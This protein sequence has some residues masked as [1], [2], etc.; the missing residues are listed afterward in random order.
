[1]NLKE[2]T[3]GLNRLPQGQEADVLFL[4]GKDVFKV[5]GVYLRDEK[6][7]FTLE[8][9]GKSLSQR[10]VGQTI[11]DP[12]EIRKI[13]GCPHNRYQGKENLLQNSVCFR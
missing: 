13:T 8:L 11:R 9:K 10:A 3:Q 2:L 6:G 5:E 7:K 12:A 1:M 4:N